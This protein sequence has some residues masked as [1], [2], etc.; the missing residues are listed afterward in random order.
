MLVDVLLIGGRSG[1]GKSTVG[2]EVSAQLQAAEISHCYLEGDFLD[3]AFPAPPGDPNRSQLTRDNIAAL[4]R[5]FSARGYHRLVYTNTVSVIYPEEI[6]ESLGV[7]SRVTRV[8]LTASDET[9]NE[10][11][12]Q[13][14]IGSALDL[15]IQRGAQRAVELE[16][17]APS[18]VLRIRTDGRGV[19]E[20]AAEVV[21]ATGWG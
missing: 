8:L 5:N 18:S 17:A 20:I 15:H 9:A 19:V 3:Q 10:R 4:W 11:L 12:A 21:A 6:T 7:P 2:W 13:R 1:V 16:R 14:E